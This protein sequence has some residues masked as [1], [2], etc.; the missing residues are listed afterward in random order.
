MKIEMEAITECPKCGK[1]MTHDIDLD[2]GQHSPDH[3]LFCGYAEGCSQTFKEG[4]CNQCTEFVY[5]KKWH[6]IKNGDAEIDIARCRICGRKCTEINEY[7]SAAKENK[8]SPNVYVRTD[9]TFDL[10][11]NTFECTECYVQKML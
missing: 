1:A 6:D 2:Y 4:P 8:V 9:G 11:S 3:C 5:C 7:V 10:V